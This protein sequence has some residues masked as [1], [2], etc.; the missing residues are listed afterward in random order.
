[1]SVTRRVATAWL[2]V[3]GGLTVALAFGVAPAL[4]AV[5]PRIEEEFVTEV[6][7]SGA[8]L[9]AKIDPG[10]ALTS[11]V[12]EYAPAGG[13]FTAVGEV[14]G[15]GSVPAGSAGVVVGVHVQNGLAAH[16]AY[17]FRVAVSNS[18]SALTGETVSFVTQLGGGELELLDGRQWQLVT[19]PDKH[20]SSIEPQQREGG[21]IQAA[22]N[23]AAISY[24]ANGPVTSEPEGNR[25]PEMVQVLSRRGPAGWETRDIEAPEDAAKTFAIGAGSE[26]RVFST[27]LSLALVQPH[28]E[29]PLSPEASERTP[30]LREDATGR[31]VP[32]AT[33]ANTPPG[34]EFGGVPT[35]DFGDIQLAGATPDLSHVVVNSSVALTSQSAPEGG[36]Y[37]WSEGR[38]RLVSVLPSGEPVQEG[39]FTALGFGG[40]G[41]RHAISDDGSRVIWAENREDHLELWSA[42]GSEAGHS[43]QLDTVQA[44]ASGA[45]RVEPQFQTASSDG[46]KIFFTDSQ[47][48]TADA[49]ATALNE[50]D[51][52]ECEIIEAPAGPSCELSDIS[53][54]LNAGET[55]DVRGAVLGA[56]EDG[57]YVYFVAGGVLA[58]GGKAGAYNLYV[59]HEGATRL[60]AALSAGDMNWEDLHNY[61]EPAE[62]PAAVS[63]NGRYLAFMSEESLTGYDNHD[64]ANGEADEEVF[65]YDAQGGEGAGRLVCAS[66]DPTGARPHGVYDSGIYPGLLVDHRKLW[67]G[68]WLAGS[69]PGW[70]TIDLTQAPY[71]PRYLSN[72][73][74][75]FFDSPD[76]L[77]AQADNGVEDVYE[78]EPAGVGGCS[79]ASGLFGEGSGGCVGLISGGSSGEESAFLDASETGE[80]VFFLTAAPLVTSDVDS[81]YDIYDAQVCSA[82]EPC[83]P[84]PVSPPP[85]ATVDSCRAAP[86]PQPAIFGAPASQTFSGEGNPASAGATVKARAHTPTRAQLLAKALSACHRAHGARKRRR[87]ERAARERYGATARH[88]AHGARDARGGAVRRVTRGQA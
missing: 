9:S 58:P 87:C 33:A 55:A 14:E 71:Q 31:Y 77:V 59:R 47:R 85:C 10:E 38:F 79:P 64:A 24:I 83:V 35:S 62:L 5:A 86:S 67:Q 43:I 42:H 23:G 73:G 37:E 49:S 51:L 2:W 70:T 66:C 44:G 6:T 4:G 72:S 20:G 45:E 75:L 3:A 78:Y 8:T 53:V 82:S 41:V 7:S 16:T 61:G 50:P 74:R 22:A 76:A 19:P 11:Y 63:A 46:S 34:T 56:S 39:N 27:D 30:Y 29:T 68:H 54:P 57:S 80:D 15:R 48:L 65:L 60:I 26:Y 84:A 12:F 28:G 18:A 81:A 17:E 21:A 69:V 52:Y 32:L 1:M 88:K 13:S 36:L 25:A 40:I